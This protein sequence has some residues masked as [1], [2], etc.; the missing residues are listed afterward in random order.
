MALV[1][2][3]EMLISASMAD[4]ILDLQVLLEDTS[5]FINSLNRRSVPLL[6][7]RVEVGLAFT[8]PVHDVRGADM[9]LKVL[10]RRFTL[11]PSMSYKVGDVMTGRRELTA[12]LYWGLRYDDSLR[13][14]DK[15]KKKSPERVTLEGMTELSFLPSGKIVS[16]REFWLADPPF[17]AKKDYLSSIN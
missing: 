2:F 11:L 16:W 15:V 8:D 17:K 4:R 6:M 9:A 13:F 12:C 14:M 1:I 5:K 10:E 7:D 3:G